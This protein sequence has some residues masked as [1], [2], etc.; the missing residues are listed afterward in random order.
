MAQRS[1]ESSVVS[2]TKGEGSREFTFRLGK[3]RRNAAFIFT[4]RLPFPSPPESMIF[5]SMLRGKTG[6]VV[7]RASTRL[8]TSFLVDGKIW[9]YKYKLGKQRLSK[10]W[11]AV[12]LEKSRETRCV[13]VGKNMEEGGGEEK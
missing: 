13:S 4:G 2:D 1:R 12:I 11:R 5:S 10:S 6:N 7:A 8:T 9:P 3:Q